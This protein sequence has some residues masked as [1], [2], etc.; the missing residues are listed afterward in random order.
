MHQAFDARFDF[1]KRA[2]VGDVGD[3]A[4][5]AG[6]LRV[7]TFDVHPGI[8][9]ELLEAERDAAA[10]AIVLED[11]DFDF[12][13]NLHD[14]CRIL[15]ALPGHVGD[16]QQAVDTAE[17]HERAVFDEVLDHALEHNA[18][19]QV[20]E[21]AVTLGAVFGFEHFATRNNDVVAQLVELDDLEFER[22]AFEVRSIANRTDVDQ[23]TG[24]ERT[25]GAD[26]DGE[27][28]LD[29]AGD[30]A[31]DGFLE[32]VGLGQT[33]PGLDAFCFFLAELGFAE[34]VFDGFESHFNLIANGNFQLAVNHEF[35]NIDDAFGLQACI[36]DD[37]VGVNCQHDRVDDGAR[38]HR[39]A[40][41]KAGLKKFCKT[42][43]HL[44]T[45]VKVEHPPNPLRRAC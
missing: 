26:V 16:V 41:L 1:N 21:E 29:L 38:L 25:H 19:L 18:F 28:A 23:R 12:S 32:F 43:A 24:Q 33:F 20:L 6:L 31:D 7:T 22:L 5:Q 13:A 44:T 45:L 30:D 15:D 4:E 36:D 35:F 34:A 14:F 9:T 42:L 10:F 39:L 27:A 37:D 17:V 40:A 2:V 3:L 8:G 11:L